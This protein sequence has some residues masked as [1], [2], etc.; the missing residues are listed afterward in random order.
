MMNKAELKKKFFEKQGWVDASRMGIHEG[1]TTRAWNQKLE[2]IWQFIEEEIIGEYEKKFLCG[3]LEENNGIPFK[4][5]CGKEV[6]IFDSYRCADCTASFHR[7]CIREHFN[8]EE[9]ELV[10]FHLGYQVAQDERDSQLTEKAHKAIEL[11][12][13]KYEKILKL[14]IVSNE[15]KE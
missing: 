5:G 10:G 6:S 3:M 8:N 2:D 1:L 11:R 12:A 13:K 7:D 15:D 14:G 9:K 4:G